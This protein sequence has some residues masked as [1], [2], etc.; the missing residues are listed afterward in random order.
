MVPP[1]RKAPL[2]PLGVAEGSP[3]GWKT[4]GRRQSKLGF[5]SRE[6]FSS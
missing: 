2:T 1:V 5:S 3:P 6:R 4:V